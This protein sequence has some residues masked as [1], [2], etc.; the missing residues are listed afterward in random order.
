MHVI[1]Y[2]VLFKRLS[3]T[4]IVVIH[5]DLRYLGNSDITFQPPDTAEKIK[6]ASNNSCKLSSRF[7][8]LYHTSAQ[9]FLT[10]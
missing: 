10:Q 5:Y 3:Y 6:S 2:Y 7:R 9:F 1:M 8:V 4:H